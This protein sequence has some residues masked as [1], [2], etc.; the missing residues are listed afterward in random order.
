[1]TATDRLNESDSITVTIN[2]S[3]V[4]DPPVAA[5]D[6]AMTAEDKE[7][8]IRVLDNDTDPDTPRANLRV[9]V[10]TQP[11]NGRA[12]VEADKTITYTPNANFAG[13]NSFTY[14]LS[15]GSL[16]DDGSVTVTVEAVNDAPTFP[17][18]TAARSV[19]ESAEADANVGAPVTATDIDSA[20]LTY[21]LSGADASSFD[22]DSDGQITVGMG[23]TFDAAMKDEYAV[24]VTADDRQGETAMVEV[25]I[26]VTAGANPPAAAD[27]HHHRRRRRWRWRAVGPQPERGR[28]RVDRDP[29]HR[30][31]RQ[32]PRQ[33]LGHV[34]RRRDALGPRER[35][36]RRRRHLRLRPQATGE[37]VRSASS[38]SPRR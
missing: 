19:P 13:E 20:M 29:R 11:L 35:G 10:L 32:R 25:T 8:I 12:R 31:A 33:A 38:S 21:R 23:V 26:T 36:R 17:S 34:V 5:N 2:V 7:V 15:D 22:I 28:L 9:S 14:R 18:S 24:T 1:M 3:N 6:T 27:H 30:G 37:R 4:N 16:S